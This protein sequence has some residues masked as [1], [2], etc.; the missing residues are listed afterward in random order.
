LI[1]IIFFAKQ[2]IGIHRGIV[3][4]THNLISTV[5]DRRLTP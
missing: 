1:G 3:F 4:I 5:V 2:T